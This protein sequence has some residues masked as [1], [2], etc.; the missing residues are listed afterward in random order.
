L[1]QNDGLIFWTGGIPPP[2]MEGYV[3]KFVGAA[4]LAIL[5]ASGGS[6]MAA[7]DY[8]EFDGYCDFMGPVTENGTQSL[9]PH[10]L[11][12]ECGFANNAVAVGAETTIVGQTGKWLVF[13]SNFLDAENG[14][15]SGGQA[16]YA[17]QLPLRTGNSWFVFETSDGATISYDNAGTYTI[18]HRAPK[19][20][21]VK[22][23]ASFAVHAAQLQPAR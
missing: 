4:A 23:P 16:Y 11:T 12:T 7:T 9:S 3:N 8:I 17:V 6:A 13:A 10:N 19:A 22:L 18:A 15:Y 20:E 21:R 5:C 1:S 2:K 14:T